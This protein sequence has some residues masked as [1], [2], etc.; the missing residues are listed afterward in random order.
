MPEKIHKS[1]DYISVGSI[2]NIILDFFR[3]L[4]RAIDFILL[5]IRRRLG[6]FLFCCL[7]GIAGGFLYYWQNPAYYKTEMIVKSNDLTRKAFY[8]ILANLNY[9]ITSQSH[10]A[11]SAQLK[12][13]PR[14]GKDVLAINAVDINNATLQTDTST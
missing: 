12:L 11:F 2:K 10:S 6:L 8:E 13:D 5:S 9:L 1:D 7:I 14:L 3:F 4:F